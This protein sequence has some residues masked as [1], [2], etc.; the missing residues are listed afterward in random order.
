MRV[1]R[2]RIPQW[3]SKLRMHGC[4][5][6]GQTDKKSSNENY[7]NSFAIG[8]L[9]AYKYWLTHLQIWK[10]KSEQQLFQSNYR[11]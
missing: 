4:I 6:N 8:I 3:R 2:S 10:V 9:V 7:K 5:H 11:S 1:R